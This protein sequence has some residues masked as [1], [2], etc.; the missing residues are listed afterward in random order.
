MNTT[1]LRLYF[2]EK[3]KSFDLPEH[4]EYAL[5]N[6][7]VK[8]YEIYTDD[9]FKRIIGCSLIYSAHDHDGIISCLHYIVTN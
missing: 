4:L 7:Y 9:T 5:E 3:T 8:N 1:D 2:Y 6:D